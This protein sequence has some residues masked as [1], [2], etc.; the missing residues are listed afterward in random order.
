MR[1]H[2]LTWLLQLD[3][4]QGA[5]SFIADRIIWTVHKP[6]PGGMLRG[7]LEA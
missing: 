4:F 7:G 6:S 2:S 3:F 1:M 5:A